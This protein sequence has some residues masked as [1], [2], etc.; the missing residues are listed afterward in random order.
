[1]KK[2]VYNPKELNESKL[3]TIYGFNNGGNPG[4]FTGQL[5]AEDGTPLGSHLC[6]HEVFMPGD[7]GIVKAS[8]PDRHETFREH[9]PDGYKMEFVS[10]AEIKTHKGLQDAFKNNAKL[11]VEETKGSNAS[12]EVEV[13]ERK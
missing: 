3:P 11:D 13:I 1:M 10:A 7:L 4:W 12:I 8:R 5:I 6:S 9:Y 2:E